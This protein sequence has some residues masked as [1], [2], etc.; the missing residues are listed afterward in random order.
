LVDQYKGMVFGLAMRSVTDRA[1]A[2]E[3]AQDVFLKIHKGLVYFRGES[4]LS[5]WIYRIVLNTLSQE[6][7]TP[8]GV[9]LDDPDRRSV[10][11]ALGRQD[12]ALSGMVLR[13]RLSK[14]VARLPPN[15]QILINAHYLKGVQYEE[16][17]EALDLPLGTVKTHLHRAKREL[18]RLLETD[19]R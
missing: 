4:K 11:E 2:E 12:E 18:R 10:V 7:R 6:R 5:T 8:P 15:Y 9:S 19:F 16:L 17:A 3:I 14:A 13:D 1:R